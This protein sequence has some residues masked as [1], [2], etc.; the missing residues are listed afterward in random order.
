MRKLGVALLILP[1]AGVAWAIIE[2]NRAQRAVA[3]AP[4]STLSRF[5]DSLVLERSP[6]YGTCPAY[7]LRLRKDGDVLFVSHDAGDEGRAEQGTT[8]PAAFL[9]L[10]SLA[11]STGFYELPEIIRND[12]VYCPSMHTDAPTMTVSIFGP[13]TKRVE[14]Y[15]G[16]VSM[17]HGK[18]LD[19]SVGQQRLENTIDSAAGVKK[20]ILP[21]PGR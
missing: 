1:L 12:R 10:L 20:W 11:D 14:R 3:N 15:G 2:G 4:P 21:A 9:Y 7:R 17:E 19:W 18:V 16:C 6:C 5:V 13:R 8:T